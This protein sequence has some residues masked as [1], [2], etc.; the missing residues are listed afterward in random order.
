MIPSRGIFWK[1]MR[2]GTR[3]PRR[4]SGSVQRPLRGENSRF[5]RRTVVNNLG[6]LGP[7]MKPGMIEGVQ[8]HGVVLRPNGERRLDEEWT[9]EVQLSPR[10]G[11]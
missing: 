8:R 4:Q 10:N 2:L 3:D 5:S 6:I 1:D 7:G 9:S 11:R